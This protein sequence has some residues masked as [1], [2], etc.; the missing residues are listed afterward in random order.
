MTTVSLLPT[1]V[2]LEVLRA[3]P[4]TIT[5]KFTDPIR[6]LTTDTVT[7]SVYDGTDGTLVFEHSNAPGGHSSPAL[8][9]GG[10]T[11]FVLTAADTDDAALESKTAWTFEV[12]VLPSGGVVGTDD[13]AAFY[14]TFVVVPRPKHVAQP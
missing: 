8:A 3:D 13:F 4:R 14:G 9:D 1:L 7:F 12:R 10:E 2:N 11:A 6:D 5:F